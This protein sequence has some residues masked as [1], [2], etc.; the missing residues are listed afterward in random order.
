MAVAVSCWL[1][2]GVTLCC[3]FEGR[4]DPHSVRGVFYASRLGLITCM[5]SVGAALPLPQGLRGSRRW[6]HVCDT[7]CRS[8]LLITSGS[9]CVVLTYHAGMWNPTVSNRVTGCDTHKS[10]CLVCV[11]LPSRHAGV[12]QP[13]VLT[14]VWMPGVFHRIRHRWFQHSVAFREGGWRSVPRANLELQLL[15]CSCSATNCVWFDKRQCCAC[16]DK[17]IHLWLVRQRLP[18]LPNCNQQP[19]TECT[20]HKMF[21][22]LNVQYKECSEH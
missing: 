3:S 21:S 15:V 10:A 14:T 6:S 8:V 22:K 13:T 5:Y 11:L 20:V 16:A 17:G 7:R 4:F 1:W 18:P 9:C 2:A 12:C 19:V